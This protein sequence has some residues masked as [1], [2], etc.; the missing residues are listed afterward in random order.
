MV[1]KG[2]TSVS[3]L[4]WGG[5]SRE[6]RPGYGEFLP[7]CCASAGGRVRSYHSPTGTLL[8]PVEDAGDRLEL[9]QLD[10]VAATHARGQEQDLF[11]NVGRQIEEIHDLRDARAADLAQAG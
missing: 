2:E 8:V 1:V 4:G 6:F 9:A 7:T 11:L 10:E 3:Y 5:T